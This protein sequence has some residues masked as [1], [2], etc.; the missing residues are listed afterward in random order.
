MGY[1]FVFKKT[2]ICILIALTL[3]F[4]VSACSTPQETISEGSE[5]MV[6]HSRSREKSGGIFC[7]D[8]DGNITNQ[9]S[10]FDMQDLSFYSF[11]ANNLLVSGGRSN[12]NIVFDFSQEGLFSEI[13]WLNEPN[14]TGVTAV[15]LYNQSAFVVMNGNFTDETYLNL[16]VEQDFQ[17]N[18]VHQSIIELYCR[19]IALQNKVA[20]IVGKHLKIENNNRIWKASIIEYDIT[21]QTMRNQSDY[22]QYNCFWEIELHNGLYYCLAEDKNELK[23]IVCVID[24]ETNT[25]LYEIKIDDQLTGME[26]YND[27]A[28]VIGNNGIYKMTPE[29][30]FEK[31]VE[32]GCPEDAYVNWAYIYDG[33]YYVFTRLQQRESIKD[34]YRY[35]DILKID[36]DT[37]EKKS[38]PIKQSKDIT[39]DDILIFPVHM[40]N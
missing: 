34:E 26:I 22:G 14:Y 32:I 20:L 38:S 25:V 33:S 1:N 16:V 29:Q 21:G 19:D 27:E 6:I 5:Y 10:R 23:N 15:E 28:F 35:G 7:I 17:G 9:I 3:C 12:N 39:M 8:N 37:L 24:P 30:H 2:T 4:V 13:H 36:L 31:I 40:F 18:V 11:S